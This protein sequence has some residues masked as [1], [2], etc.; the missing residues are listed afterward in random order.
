MPIKADK[1]APTDIQTIDGVFTKRQKNND[2]TR[3][4][5]F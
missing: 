2:V 3:S 4:V 1:S 5:F